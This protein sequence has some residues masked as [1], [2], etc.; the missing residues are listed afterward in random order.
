MRVASGLPAT[1]W[2]CARVGMGLKKSEEFHFS[3]DRVYHLEMGCDELP[4]ML[5]GCVVTVVM[6]QPPS[7]RQRRICPLKTTCYY[8]DTQR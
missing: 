3:F 5:C 7:W 4:E 6:G 2:I 8:M 1:P